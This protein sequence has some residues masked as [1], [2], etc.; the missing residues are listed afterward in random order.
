MT[1]QAQQREKNLER[2]NELELCMPHDEP[3][4]LTIAPVGTIAGRYP[5]SL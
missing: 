4:I 1:D 5:P 3:D 2:A